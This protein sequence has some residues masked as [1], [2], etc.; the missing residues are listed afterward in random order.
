M[1]YLK[2]GLN[3]VFFA[4]ALTLSIAQGAIARQSTTQPTANPPG[5]VSSQTSHNRR[6]HRKPTS[7]HHRHHKSSS[8]H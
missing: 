5:K 4:G 8:K 3:L 6:H 2:Y 1:K 7:Q